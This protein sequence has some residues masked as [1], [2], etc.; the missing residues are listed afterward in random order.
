MRKYV[1]DLAKIAAPMTDLLKGKF[2]R[3]TWARDCHENFEGLKKTLMKIPVFRIMEPLKDG[4]SLYIDASD[5]TIGLWYNFFVSD[6]HFRN[7][8]QL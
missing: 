1:T 5:I 3:I 2:K 7:F 8:E 4:L 6:N